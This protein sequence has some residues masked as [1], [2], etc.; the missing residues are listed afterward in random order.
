MPVAT[1]TRSEGVPRVV[2][3]E[4]KR[5]DVMDGW[6]NRKTGPIG[7]VPGAD[8]IRVAQIHRG[9]HG[10]FSGTFAHLPGGW[11]EAPHESSGAGGSERWKLQLPIR[12]DLPGTFRGRAT[13]VA[14]QEAT[15]ALAY[16]RLR[17][18]PMPAEERASAA[19]WQVAR[20]L[21]RPPHEL[22][23]G[24]YAL[25]DLQEGDRLR[26]EVMAVSAS[27]SELEALA[28]KLDI[29][30]WLPVGMEDPVGALARVFG[31]GPATMRL[32]LLLGERQSSWLVVMRAGC[33][34][35]V[36]PL[37]LGRASWAQ[38][39]LL[40][41]G[42]GPEQAATLQ[43]GFAAWEAGEARATLEAV[44]P[45]LGRELVHDIALCLRHLGLE[46]QREPLVAAVVGAGHLTES[47]Q[48]E[49]QR[50]IQTMDR[51]LPAGLAVMLD[52]LHEQLP[53]WVLGLLR[54]L[55]TQEPIDAWLLP[56]GLALHGVSIP[57]KEAA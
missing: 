46:E 9:W 7:M 42:G 12:R 48:R 32:L 21:G 14:V 36:H 3:R 40:L 19:H 10:S 53:G 35:L 31:D 38:R 17:L 37:R 27:E 2:E 39:A 24:I 50:S 20:E 23:S 26:H 55:P 11:S 34:V 57:S 49:L 51:G 6:M 4:K 1:D 30:G 15:E 43:A 56:L 22:R 41:G 25:G 47:L 8:G 44:L 52:P 5:C 45:L 54:G 33:P 29:A 13:V 16:R 18:A 28:M